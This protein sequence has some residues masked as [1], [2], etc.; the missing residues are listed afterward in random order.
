MT[1]VEESRE[2]TESAIYDQQ[3]MYDEI[4]GKSQEELDRYFAAIR[5]KKELQNSTKK[6]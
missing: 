4:R 2:Q 6:K 5:L 1:C 3:A